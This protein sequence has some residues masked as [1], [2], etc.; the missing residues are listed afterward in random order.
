VKVEEKEEEVRGG[1]TV[2]RHRHEVGFH[3]G[4]ASAHT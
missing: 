1:E 3:C 2:P 4:V